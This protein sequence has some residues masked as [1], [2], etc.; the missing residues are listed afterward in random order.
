MTSRVGR[1]FAPH[2]K[3]VT[4]VWMCSQCDAYLPVATAAQKA[5]TA[6]F[7]EN[8]QAEV[9]GFCKKEINEYLVDNLMNQTAE[10]LSDPDV[11]DDKDR[12]A[13]Y[14]RVIAASLQALGKF[15]K[16]VDEDISNE[17]VHYH[18]SLIAEKKFWKLGRHKSP[19]IRAS[20]FFLISTYCQRQPSI[21]ESCSSSV[22]PIVLGSLD[23][24][25]AIV[26]GPLWE[27]VLQLVTRMKDCWKYVNMEKAVLPKFWLFLSNA[28]YGNAHVVMISVLPFIS[29]LP[30]EVVF[31]SSGF[32]QKLLEKTVDGLKLVKTQQSPSE[33]KAV[34]SSFMDCVKYFISFGSRHWQIEVD[35]NNMEQLR[36]DVIN[37]LTNVIEMSLA[38]KPQMRLSSSLLYERLADF[39]RD[40][41][42]DAEIQDNFWE[43]F[44]QLIQD[45]ML[46]SEKD[47]APT[48]QS[49]VNLLSCL[50]SKQSLQESEP[51]KVRFHEPSDSEDQS[52]TTKIKT[53]RHTK[54]S[55]VDINLLYGG[56]L[57]AT[58][59]KTVCSCLERV[60]SDN[61]ETD[62]VLVTELVHDFFSTSLLND[63]LITVKSLCASDF[64]SGTSSDAQHPAVCTRCIDEL[65]L[66]LLDKGQQS[67]KWLSC[68]V[69]LL[70]L[71]LVEI[72]DSEQKCVL[73]RVFQINSSP[74]LLYLI[75]N[76]IFKADYYLNWSY[77]HG[78]QIG[79]K[80]AEV[81]KKSLSSFDE[82]TVDTSS[83]R[84][85]WKT[86][87]LCFL[88]SHLLEFFFNENAASEIFKVF[89]LVLSQENVASS[90]IISVVQLIEKYIQNKEVTSRQYEAL[91]NNVFMDVL[92]LR[93]R[94]QEQ[95]HVTQCWN[96]LIDTAM[97]DTSWTD[98]VIS[99]TGQ[100]IRDF[101][102]TGD[103]I[104]FEKFSV[105][106][107][108][109]LEVIDSVSKNDYENFRKFLR[110]LS[111]SDLDWGHLRDDTL[112]KST[113]A[114]IP[115]LDGSLS[116]TQF[117]NNTCVNDPEHLTSH[118][119]LC[120]FL[121]RVFKQRYS[122]TNFPQD[123]DADRY[124]WV[125]FTELLWLR[126]YLKQTVV[127]RGGR[128]SRTILAAMD[129]NLQPLFN[130]LTEIS[131]A[132]LSSRLLA[133]S[134]SEGGLWS[135]TLKSVMTASINDE[136]MSHF[137]VD[138]MMSEER[139][140]NE[141]KLQTLQCLLG[142]ETSIYNL[143][144]IVEN[145]SKMLGEID[146]SNVTGQMFCYSVLSSALER[147]IHLS[148]D[149]DIAALECRLTLLEV[150]K[151]IKTRQET[152]TDQLLFSCCLDDVEVSLISLNLAIMRI[153]K[154]AV[155]NFSESMESELWDMILCSML[156]WLQSCQESAMVNN[157]VSA[158]TNHVCQMIEVVAKNLCK[159]TNS[160][161]AEVNVDADRTVLKKLS[162][163]WREFFSVSASGN[164]L[165]LWSGIADA[166]NSSGH[167][168]SVCHH[169]L[170]E[171]LS[172]ACCYL[173]TDNLK[174]YITSS[175]GEK[176]AECLTWEEDFVRKF[177]PYL[178]SNYSAFQ[179][180]A[181][182]LLLR[183]IPSVKTPKE[184]EGQSGGEDDHDEPCKSPPSDLIELLTKNQTKLSFIL[185]EA[186]VPF[187]ESLDMEDDHEA[188][189]ITRIYL[190]AWKLLLVH[191]TNSNEELRA[192]YANYLRREKYLNELLGI[193]FRILPKKPREK[194]CLVEESS[195]EEKYLLAEEFVHNLAFETYYDL[196]R[197]LPAL[198]RQWWNNL[199]KKYAMV[200]EKY[201]TSYISPLLCEKEIQTIQKATATYDNMEIVTRSSTREVIAYYKIEDISIELIVS[202]SSSYP[203]GLINVT[204]GKRVG[205]KLNQWRLW[206]M[207]L[208]TFLMHQN[209]T[210][211]DGLLLWK[212]NVD[213]KFE[214][215]D[216]CMICFSV[217]HGS[218]YSLPTLSCKT[219]KKKF[220]SACLYR[221]FSTSNNSTCPLCR[222]LF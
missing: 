163:E 97:S 132:S 81:L 59:S 134:K 200:V 101:L 64:T 194:R 203:L 195:L 157:H 159:T 117:P 165:R 210:I 128:L 39:L 124:E 193:V 119:M 54:G 149:S 184:E 7:S 115:F 111:P 114:V 106:T 217:I 90:N 30:E 221:W 122:T 152:M 145:Y 61:S 26:S 86:L 21:I 89:H 207:Q 185:S 27:A 140:Y 181:Y 112:S 16:M 108:A 12:S 127:T 177:L 65:V 156:D 188:S 199:E 49:I 168:L 155:M 58:V 183:V 169:R 25:D 2:L 178:K 71:L 218:N 160:A 197:T 84:F 22:C 148:Q 123:D 17:I 215:V 205:V 92:Q 45:K 102:C 105:F 91:L 209:G 72:D 121:S 78:I 11:V 79:T 99:Q 80:F 136:S 50:K 131:R 57:L 189:H 167:Q 182:R 150:L 216:D 51:S 44:D 40:T 138:L 15:L 37:M 104:T 88:H 220:H 198:V 126:E 113:W 52:T 125:M 47:M 77:L 82:E 135:F 31:P 166:D 142:V 56:R 141:Q 19:Q 60:W 28:A 34:L 68:T 9:L 174:E 172:A 196:L 98:M 158:M 10:T 162:D 110:K 87:D 29:T 176:T 173:T 33:C 146:A 222:N 55:D 36:T 100:Q 46:C 120:L 186:E 208:T 41:A 13:K 116:F 48:F 38:A 153:M 53:K 212:R 4:G 43:V 103:P 161:Q 147:W 1:N 35:K 191:F 85:L 164:L 129:T 63:I 204:C 67:E 75:V 96:S 219:C 73:E 24:A 20:F 171:T 76:E 6:A 214:G 5:F 151:D 66:H 137:L 93:L 109:A 143:K 175:T 107:D 42:E 23:E 70:F 69:Q 170:S 139:D 83:E 94:G 14:V 190:L 118:Q 8:K 180:A 32:A 95:T 192:G 144:V 133:I 3:S 206:M 179:L 154:M 211:L 18:T 201:T 187:G 74:D 202:L 130:A 213:K 62:L